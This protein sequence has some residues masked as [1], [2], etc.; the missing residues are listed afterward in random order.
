MAD[1][2]EIRTKKTG[3]DEAPE[4]MKKAVKKGL[5]KTMEKSLGFAKYMAPYRTGRLSGRAG[6]EGGI[7]YIIVVDGDK[8]TGIMSVTALD[9]TTGKDYSRFIH[10]GTGV[11]G[12]EKKPI[13][14][15]KEGGVLVWLAD[16][17]PNPTTAEGWRAEHQAKNVIFAKE[18]EGIEGEPFLADGLEEGLKYAP[19][20][21]HIEFVDLNNTVTE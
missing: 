12:P 14:P 4:N 8:I 21:F 10:D 1:R 20:F 19:D 17:R 3:V 5:G 7:R 6:G 11:Y 16:G 9:P 15:K 18:V 2:V 13:K